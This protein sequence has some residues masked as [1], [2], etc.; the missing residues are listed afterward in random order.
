[1]NIEMQAAA[2][3]T[4]VNFKG[5]ENYFLLWWRNENRDKPLLTP[6]IGFKAACNGTDA[7]RVK[8]LVHFLLLSYLILSHLV[9][10]CNYNPFSQ[11]LFITWLSH[12][13][14]ER[15]TR[16][17]KVIKWR[18]KHKIVTWN[19]EKIIKTHFLHSIPQH[20]RFTSSSFSYNNT[21][22]S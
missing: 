8:N 15:K 13:Q 2:L 14:K 3:F 10:H 7:F 19:T 1:M 12:K 21:F 9:I 4:W 22:L 6:I 20:T 16:R 17:K 18:Y 5:N 11:S